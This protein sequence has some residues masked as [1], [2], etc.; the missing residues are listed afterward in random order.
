MKIIGLILV[1]AGGLL[2]YAGITGKN[3]GELFNRE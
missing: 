2:A 3:L 1:I